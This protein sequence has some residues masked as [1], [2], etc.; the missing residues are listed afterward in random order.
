MKTLLLTA[1]L[2]SFTVSA[3]DNMSDNEF[4][5]TVSETAEAVMQNRQAGSDMADLY[6]ITKTK[7]SRLMVVEA[8]KIPQYSTEKYRKREV[9]AFKN[10]WFRS[11]I[12]R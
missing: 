3:K 5:E 9:M 4:C 6:K 2:L 10:S 12:T 11:C 8:Y 1:A 7:M